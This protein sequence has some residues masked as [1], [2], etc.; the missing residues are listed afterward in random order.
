MSHGH[1][2]TLL[3]TATNPDP[4]T[5]GSD[6]YETPYEYPSQKDETYLQLLEDMN[7]AWGGTSP[8]GCILQIRRRVASLSDVLT[9]RLFDILKKR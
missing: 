8:D 3:Q 4:K 7:R 2:S 6:C 1:V 9:S 5:E